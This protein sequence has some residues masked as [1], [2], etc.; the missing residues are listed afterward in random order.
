MLARWRSWK[1]V[2]EFTRKVSNKERAKIQ[3]KRMSAYVY[4]EEGLFVLLLS[5]H[6][7]HMLNVQNVKGVTVTSIFT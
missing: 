4:K 7:R 1:T 6:V 2:N 3:T 5:F